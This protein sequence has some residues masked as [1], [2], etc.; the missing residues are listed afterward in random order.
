MRVG[1]IGVGRAGKIHLEAWKAVEGAEVQAISDRASSVRRW[2][3]EIGLRAYSDPLDMIAREPLDA[4]SVATPPLLHA[5][6]T[7]ACLE[8]NLDVLCEKPLALNGREALKML[9]TATRLKRQ[10]VLATKFRHVPDLVAARDLIAAGD[11]GE[12]VAFEIDFSSMVDMS[13]RWNSRRALA[14]GGVIIDNGCHAFDIVA[15]LFG[16]VARVHATRLKSLQ[17]IAVE[18]S[19]TILVAAGRGLIGRIDLSWSLATGRETY[20]TVY[21]S[22]GTIEVGWRGSRLRVAGRPT[23]QI[24]SGYDKGDAHRRMMTAFRDLA[25]GNAVGPWITPGECL[26][27][28]AAVEAAYQSLRSGGWVSVDMMGMRESR[29]QPAAEASA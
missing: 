1:I 19:A 7:V 22:R 11:I 2:A 18:D 26:R 6:V 10:L 3:R 5:P 25:L 23:V 8:R 12:P 21:G 28:V 24:G 13:G 4:V 16:T 27:T 29:P 14:G 20:V 17:S 9:R 15:F